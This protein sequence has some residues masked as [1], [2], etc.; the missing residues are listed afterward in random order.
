MEAFM[1]LF[2]LHQEN[3][4]KWSFQRFYLLLVIFVIAAVMQNMLKYNTKWK[5]V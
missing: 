2:F 5:N 3:S 1:L 4:S